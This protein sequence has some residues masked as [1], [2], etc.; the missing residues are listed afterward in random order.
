MPQM[1]PLSWLTL[2]LTFSF[3]LIL[4]TQINYSH[5]NFTSMPNNCLIITPQTQMNWSW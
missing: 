3:M 1:S 4:L 2:M 5:L